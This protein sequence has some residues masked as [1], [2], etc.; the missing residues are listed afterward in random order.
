MFTSFTELFSLPVFGI[1]RFFLCST[2]ISSQTGHMVWIVEPSECF[3]DMSITSAFTKLYI[4][5]MFA[6]C[7][8]VEMLAA[9]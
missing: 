1:A 2:L 9:F 4:I 7:F 3:R 8:R 5:T 6:M